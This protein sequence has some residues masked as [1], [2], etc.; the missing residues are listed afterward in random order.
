VLHHG[1]VQAFGDR[2]EILQKMIRPAS[3]AIQHGPAG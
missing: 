2:S 1:Q 3:A